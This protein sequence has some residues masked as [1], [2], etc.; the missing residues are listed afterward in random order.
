MA[1]DLLENTLLRLKSLEIKFDDLEGDVLSHGTYFAEIETDHEED[2]D[3]VEKLK[4]R[5]AHIEW[6]LQPGLEKRFEAQQEELINQLE[7]ADRKYEEKFRVLNVQNE[8]LRS[9]LNMTI[10]AVNNILRILNS[11]IEQKKIS[12]VEVN[13]VT[14]SED[15][16]Q[17]PEEDEQL[18]LSQVYAMYQTQPQDEEG[19]EE[20]TNAIKAAEEYEASLQK[21]QELS[22][23][24]NG[25]TQ[26]EWNDLLRI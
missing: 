20:M 10:D 16:N 7:D 11:L 8:E 5:V 23:R 22:T 18:T 2:R 4:E 13:E 1:Q 17:A 26:D 6:D 25:L 3:K 14:M 9:H 19:W 21:Q 15:D 24:V 12:L